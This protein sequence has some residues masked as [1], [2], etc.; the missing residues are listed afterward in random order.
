MPSDTCWAA[1]G[2]GVSELLNVAVKAVDQ[3][4]SRS[5]RVLL[6]A[7]DLLLMLQ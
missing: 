5:M 1:F 3:K 6:L 4:Q 7:A 2:G